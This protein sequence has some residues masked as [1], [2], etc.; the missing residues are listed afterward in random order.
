MEEKKEKLA[1]EMKRREDRFKVLRKES[2]EKNH[3]K[4]QTH[5]ER[6]EEKKKKVHLKHKHLKEY[7]CILLQMDKLVSERESTIMKA[8]SMAETSAQLRNL[9]R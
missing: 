1:E 6:I 7:I 8:R 5:K 3:N 4:K 9:I 2:Q